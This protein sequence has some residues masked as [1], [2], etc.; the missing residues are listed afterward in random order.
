[1]PFM[2]ANIG[3]STVPVNGFLTGCAASDVRSFYRAMDIEEIL[4]RIERRLRVLGLSANAA[5]KLANKPDAI[6]N[7]Q[8]AAKNPNGRQGVSTATLAALA[9]V[10]KTTLAWLISGEGVEEFAGNVVKVVGYVGAGA[11]VEPDF[12]QVPPEGLEQIELIFPVPEGVLGF[13]VR[14]KYMLPHYRDGTVLLVREHTTRPIESFFGEEA[15]V[16]A[17][18]GHRYVK[19]IVYN[20]TRTSVTL[21]SFNDEPIE[22]AKIEWLGEIAAVIPPNQVKGWRIEASAPARA[23]S[24]R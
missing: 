8:R 21:L 15:V 2:A 14:G 1:M 6:R 19:T 9:P 17:A 10:L 5:S 13:K 24:A 18:D 12:E 22:K 16:R 4:A 7:L 3:I 11:S 20:G 23:A